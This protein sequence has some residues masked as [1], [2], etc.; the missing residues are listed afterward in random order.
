[1]D[2]GGGVLAVAALRAALRESGSI[3]APGSPLLGAG[4][5]RGSTFAFGCG[6]AFLPSAG[7]TMR[8][9]DSCW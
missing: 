7:S 2:G 3:L 1:L 4:F 6:G 8:D 9:A 5:G